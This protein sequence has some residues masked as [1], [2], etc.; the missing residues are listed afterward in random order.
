M[1]QWKDMTIEQRISH[2][3]AE[4]DAV[5]DAI[6]RWLIKNP[7][8]AATAKYILSKVTEEQSAGESAENFIWLQMDAINWLGEDEENSDTFC[9]AFYDAINRT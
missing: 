8:L 4:V 5:A 1:T 7:H 9:C 3:H 2:W 6:H